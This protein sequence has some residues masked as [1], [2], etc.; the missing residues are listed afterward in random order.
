M[1]EKSCKKNKN[2]NYRRKYEKHLTASFFI[3]GC[4]NFEFEH[5]LKLKLALQFRSELKL[6]NT[7]RF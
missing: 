7:K 1:S 2:R 4:I 5:R 3:E 6:Q